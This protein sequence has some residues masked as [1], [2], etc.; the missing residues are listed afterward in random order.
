MKDY[1]GT[2]FIRTPP[3]PQDHHRALDTGLLKGPRGR[4]FLM[5]QVPLYKMATYVYF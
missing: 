5:G 4:L 1:R 2:S 3:P